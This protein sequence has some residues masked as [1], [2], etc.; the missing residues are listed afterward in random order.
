MNKVRNALNA[1]I[2]MPGL[3]L[4]DMILVLRNCSRKDDALR[5]IDAKLSANESH[6]INKFFSSVPYLSDILSKDSGTALTD[7]KKLREA[8]SAYQCK[9]AC[10]CYRI[11][12]EYKLFASNQ[13]G[14]FSSRMLSYSQLT[15]LS[16]A[17]GDIIED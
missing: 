14:D 8:L 10:E 17:S 4:R 2:E 7:I 16:L 6:S 3:M 15:Y 9:L 13:F 1:G 5:S 11:A 12:K